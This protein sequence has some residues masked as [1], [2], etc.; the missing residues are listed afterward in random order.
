MA[1]S[2]R[3]PAPPAGRRDRPCADAWN[4]GRAPQPQPFACST[5]LLNAG[6]HP[7]Q[8]GVASARSDQL[9]MGAVLNQAAAF[10]GDDAVGATHGGKTVGD[11]N[12]SAASGDRF[13]VFLNNALAFV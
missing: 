11:N 5:N 13:H 10:D 8:A 7:V 2:R 12:D 4:Y 3:S 6:L 1:A 9:L